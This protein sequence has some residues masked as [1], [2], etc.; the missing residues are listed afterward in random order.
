LQWAE[1]FGLGEMGL[2]PR[3]FWSLTVREFW[4]KHD[5]FKRSEDRKRS[6]MMEHVSLSVPRK[7]ADQNAIKRTVNALR[8][9]PVKPWL[10]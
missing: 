1:L 6:L 2:M 9:Y 7:D 3:D 4:I 10:R 5:A 8:R